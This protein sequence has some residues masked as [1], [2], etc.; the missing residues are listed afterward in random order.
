MI[1]GI[2]SRRTRQL[3][4]LPNQTGWAVQILSVSQ[5]EVTA[6]SQSPIVKFLHA[7]L[8]VLAFKNTDLFWYCT[9]IYYI[10]AALYDVLVRG[11]MFVNVFSGI[12]REFHFKLLSVKWITNHIGHAS[13]QIVRKNSIIGLESA[14][15]VTNLSM[16]FHQRPDVGSTRPKAWENGHGPRTVAAASMGG[17]DYRSEF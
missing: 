10:R 2:F 12:C 16:A 1:K 14:L 7:Y 11:T 9:Y 8:L 3:P 4:Y 17:N 15:S 13:W 5:R 6:A